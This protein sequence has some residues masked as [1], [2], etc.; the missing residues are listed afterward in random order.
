MYEKSEAREKII[1]FFPRLSP[2]RNDPW[3]VCVAELHPIKRH[4]ILISA[5][6]EILKDHP[7][8]RLICIGEGQ[9]RVNLE[10]LIAKLKLEKSVFLV[11]KLAEA[12]R[13]L[14]AFDVLALVS[15]SEAYGYVIAEAGLAGLPV[16]AT[17]VGGILDM[18]THDESG[19][20][21]PPDDAQAVSRAI[22]HILA[23]PEF[24]KTLALNLTTI[25]G[26][27]TNQK[28]IRDTEVWY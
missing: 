17:K 19:L 11:G 22:S 13:F 23:E 8:L 6:P 16:V 4:H 10:A 15:K 18:I 28:M 1:D 21:V 3:L 7:T 12:A 9:E 20:L 5:L 25:V 14:K 27:R 2:H 26:P 24:A